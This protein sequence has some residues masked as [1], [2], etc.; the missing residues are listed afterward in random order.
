MKACNLLFVIF[1]LMIILTMFVAN[2]VRESRPVEIIH[3]TS[4]EYQ[5]IRYY[6]VYTKRMEWLKVTP[7]AWEKAQVLEPLPPAELSAK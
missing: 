6:W 7:E 2:Y 4:F 3:K 1:I 5:G